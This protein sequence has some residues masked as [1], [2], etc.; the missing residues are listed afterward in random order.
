M[1]NSIFIPASTLVWCNKGGG[2]YY[3]CGM[4]YIKKQNMLLIEKIRPR[5]GDSGFPLSLSE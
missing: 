5:G 1:V 4:V 3:V 2:M